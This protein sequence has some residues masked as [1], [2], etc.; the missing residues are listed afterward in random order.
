MYFLAI[1]TTVITIIFII[2]IINKRLPVI[3]TP[4]H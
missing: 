3:N 4:F 2:N 1:N